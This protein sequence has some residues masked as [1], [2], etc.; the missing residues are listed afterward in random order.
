MYNFMLRRWYQISNQTI[1][2]NARIDAR[3]NFEFDGI[4]ILSYD[5]I[6]VYNRIIAFLK[7]INIFCKI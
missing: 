1:A 4:E 6:E 7:Y 2:I 5:S 3:N